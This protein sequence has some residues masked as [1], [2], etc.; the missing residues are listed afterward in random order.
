MSGAERGTEADGEGFWA[1]WS[2]RKRDGSEAGSTEAKEAQAEPGLAPAAEPPPVP[3]R[4]SCPIPNLPA[5]D[6]ASLPP[7]ESLTPESDFS[8]FLRPGVPA[9]LRGAALRRMWSLDPSIRDFIETADYQWDFNTPGGLPP[10]F[11]DELVGEARKLLAQAIG[12]AEPDEAGPGADP[13]DPASPAPEAEP[14]PAIAEAPAAF[15]AAVGAMPGPGVPPDA[16]LAGSAPP[17]RRRHGSAL[18]A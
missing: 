4:A 13:A 2:R 1:R 7:I 9:A 3:E 11:A 18:P 12:K 8:P 16:A 10:G 5:I 14:A 17:P 6:P 15:D